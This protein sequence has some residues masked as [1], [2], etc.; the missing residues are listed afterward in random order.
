M[1]AVTAD[2]VLLVI[3]V[4]QGVHVGVGRHGLVEGRVED[5]DLGHAGEQLGGVPGSAEVGGVVQGGQPFGLGQVGPHV[6]GNDH[7]D[8]ELFPAGHHAVA[9]HV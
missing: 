9:Y 4:G 6:F 7:R 1:R 3:F 8:V 5:Q 2:V